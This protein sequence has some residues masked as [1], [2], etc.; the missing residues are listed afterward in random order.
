MFLVAVLP[1]AARLSICVW[2]E[3]NLEPKAVNPECGGHSLVF[4]EQVSYCLLTGGGSYVLGDISSYKFSHLGNR[5]LQ[6]FMRK[7]LVESIF[8]MVYLMSYIFT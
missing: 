7:P 5:C 3:P 8:W 6:L 4:K 2:A 1:R